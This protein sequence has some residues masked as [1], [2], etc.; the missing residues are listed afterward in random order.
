MFP[1]IFYQLCMMLF[2]TRM[3]SLLAVLMLFA[4]PGVA[5]AWHLDKKLKTPAWLSFSGSHR[6]RYEYLDNQ[7]RAGRSGNDELLLMQTLFKTSLQFDSIS[8][9]LE[10]L[11]ARQS[12]ADS[13]S[14]LTIGNVNA[15]DILQAYLQQ[16]HSN[17]D[18][19]H[20]MKLGRFTMDVGSRRLL[21]RNKFRNTINSFTGFDWITS[22]N[23]NS[24]IRV[25]YSLPV[26]RLPNQFDDL[27]DNQ[28][29]RDREN[30][31]VRLMGIFIKNLLWADVQDEWYFYDLDEHDHANVATKDR[32]LRT[33]GSRLYIPSQP[34][35]LDAEF[36][37]ALQW[38]HSRASKSETDNHDLDHFAYFAHME[39]GYQSDGKGY[40]RIALEFDYAS[41]DDNP[42]DGDNN[43]FDTLYGVRRGDFGPL[44]IFGPISRANI[45][46][47]A[48]R[49][50]FN[51]ATA[52]TVIATYRGLWLANDKDA[53]VTA[54]LH[55]VNGKTDSYVGQQFEARLRW[56]MI[57]NNFLLEV[58]GAHFIKGS[59][60]RNAPNASTDDD[61]TFVY[62]Q[63]TL[64]F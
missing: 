41:G 60:A 17:S 9:N 15:L 22:H 64:T 33:F 28:L 42:N 27:K 10:L 1:Q 35:H 14:S 57:P 62:T 21:A 11:D 45:I 46:S 24:Q 30:H 2:S 16:T 37:V 55:D 40:P 7:Y 34:N 31:D 6:V 25:F 53:W 5:D 59:F 58:G 38:G 61:S 36:E 32:D 63:A 23:Q 44:G 52:M 8:V 50:Q 49:L 13:D 3:L 56:N 54:K 12:L 20:T 19:T 26:S 48:I 4:Q 43:R 51:P 47:P 18:Y 39:I 29:K